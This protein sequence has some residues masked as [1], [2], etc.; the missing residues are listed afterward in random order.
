MYST[1]RKFVAK[2]A[3]DD[4]LTAFKE[5]NLQKRNV[6]ITDSQNDPSQSLFESQSTT[7]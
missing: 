1:R 7:D 6:A 5:P 2:I 4:R 3:K